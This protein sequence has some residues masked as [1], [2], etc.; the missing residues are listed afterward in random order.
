MADVIINVTAD[1]SGATNGLNRINE[2]LQGV[3]RNLNNTSTRM[4][5]FASSLGTIG[6]NMQDFGKMGTMAIRGP[7]KISEKPTLR[8]K[9]DKHFTIQ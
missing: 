4:S 5:T 7:A 9:V 8:N 3:Q 2:S 6:K 1:T